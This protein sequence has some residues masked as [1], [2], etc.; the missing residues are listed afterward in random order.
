MK[1]SAFPIVVGV[2]LFAGN[3]Q[4]KAAEEVNGTYFCSSEIEAGLMY[5][6]SLK[7]WRAAGFKEKEKFIFKVRFLRAEKKK[8]DIGGVK[9]V[10]NLT[11]KLE[12]ANW[13]E[14]CY[15]KRFSLGV[16][17]EIEGYADHK[18]LFCYTALID[19][20]FNLKTKRFLSANVHGYVNGGNDGDI[21]VLAAGKCTNIE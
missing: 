18:I 19:Y 14:P 15:A 17:S 10:Y 6:P 5:D 7:D 20:T 16:P 4:S 11:V 3:S 1:G 8:D 2:L 12:G 13:E 9:E 21:P